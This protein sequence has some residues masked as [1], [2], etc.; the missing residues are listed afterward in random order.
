MLITEPLDRLH[1]EFILWFGERLGI[2][3]VAQPLDPGMLIAPGLVVAGSI[4]IWFFIGA[5][6][7]A[8][9]RRHPYASG[10]SSPPEVARVAT[11]P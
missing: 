5:V 1:V 7:E 3:T 6:V 4:V 8:R 9:L 11:S 10:E 2:S